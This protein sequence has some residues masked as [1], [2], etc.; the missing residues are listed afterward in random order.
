MKRAFVALAILAGPPAL[1]QSVQWP[2]LPTT[3]YVAGRAAGHDDVA[4]GRA[5]FVAERDGV[6]IGKP[7]AV[8]IPQYAWYRDQGKRVPVIVIQAEEVGP[9][10]IVGAKLVSGGFIAGFIDEFDLLGQEPPR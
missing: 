6:P 3:E 8:H 5:V 1:S 9:R 10:K 7:A 4:E 2:A